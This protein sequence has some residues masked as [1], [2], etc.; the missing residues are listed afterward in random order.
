[1]KGLTFYHTFK[2][3]SCLATMSQIQAEDT[4]LLSLRQK[5]LLLTALAI[6][7]VLAFAPVLQAPILM[8][9]Y[10]ETPKKW[11]VLKERDSS[12]GNLYIL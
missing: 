1:M 9:K 6:V 7:R 5:S 2:T 10:E 4:R 8:V 12:A 3:I 11:S